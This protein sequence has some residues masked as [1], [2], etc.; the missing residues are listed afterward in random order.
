M[1]FTIRAATPEDAPVIMELVMALAEFEELTHEVTGTADQL[2]QHLGGDRPAIEGLVAE[3]EGTVV[4]YALFF[5]TYSTF[6]TQPGLYLEDVF[7][8][9]DFRR[10]GIA[11]ALIGQVAAIAV[12]RNCARFEWAVLDWNQR[13]I[14]VYEKLGAKILPDWRTCRVEGDPLRQLA[15]KAP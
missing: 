9:P 15:E 14:A 4:G 1:A 11:T 6:R 13:A 10:Q 5:S 12:E 7:V 3:Q 2:R 8:L